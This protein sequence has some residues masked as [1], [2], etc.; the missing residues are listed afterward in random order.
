MVCCISCIV[1]PVQIIVYI[2]WFSTACC[3]VC[4]GLS[5]S[6]ISHQGLGG[7]FTLLYACIW[8]QWEYSSPIQINLNRLYFIPL[9]VW[10]MNFCVE[11]V[12]LLWAYHCPTLP[13]L[14]RPVI[15]CWCWRWC[16]SQWTRDPKGLVYWKA[17]QT[18]CPAH[19]CSQTPPPPPSQSAPFPGLDSAACGLLG[20]GDN[21]LMTREVSVTCVHLS[22]AFSVVLEPKG[23]EGPQNH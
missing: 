6:E 14:V 8:L 9:D 11:C 15:A 20:F 22:Q 12:C 19:F 4:T 21:K 13:A 2:F 16:H 3:Q 18:G 17:S 5:L 7:Y 1:L 10:F 23:G